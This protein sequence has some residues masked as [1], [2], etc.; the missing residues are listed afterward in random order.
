MLRQSLRGLAVAALAVAA[1][2][3][4]AV[5]G[6]TPIS[7]CALL[8]KAGETYVLTRDI[9][10]PGG[11]A[12]FFLDADRVTLDL[13]GHTVT[14][15]D[16]AV[17]TSVFFLG[18]APRT[19]TVVKNG[20]VRNFRLGIFL[21]LSTRTTVRNVTISGNFPVGA[22]G[23]TIGPNSL[24]KD[25]IVQGS[26]G[27]GIVVGDGS[28]VEG[29]LIGGP[30]DGDGNGGFGVLGGQRTLVTRNT[31]IGNGFGG[32]PQSGL[33]P[34]ARFSGI[35]VGPNSTVT[36]N[37]VNNNDR[38]G[39][40]AGTGSLVTSNTANDNATDGIAVGARST[41]SFNTAND[42]GDNG[43]EAVC[44]STIIDN[45]VVGNGAL[46]IRTIGQGCFLRPDRIPE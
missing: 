26:G 23:I 30:G 32:S 43:I 15:P 28:Q 31:V 19:S 6:V 29:C 39:I 45:V 13:N 5:A 7:E 38:N 42:N 40:E 12:C 8:D 18:F 37:M 17:P 41:V 25:C 1:F 10:S 2:A 35:Q 24:V 11:L 9:I 34:D 14:S 33:P 22:T 36:H 21:N 3:S 27:H 44:P 4:P 20:S 46:P 16:S